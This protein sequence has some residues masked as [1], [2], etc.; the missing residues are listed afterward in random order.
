M[1]TLEQLVTD[2][3]IDD[4]KW[5]VILIKVIEKYSEV[6]E[7][8]NFMCYEPSNIVII[9]DLDVPQSMVVKMNVS[10]SYHVFTAPEIL[11]GKKAT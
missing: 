9:G 10:N 2:F 3:D 8:A 6:C 11:Q 5:R 7:A 1:Y 4:D